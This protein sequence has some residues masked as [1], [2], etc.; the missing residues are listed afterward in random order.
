LLVALGLLL[1]AVSTDFDELDAGYARL[2]P[3]LRHAVR[4]NLTVLSLLE[5]RSG[6]PDPRPMRATVAAV[7]GRLERLDGGEA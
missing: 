1:T 3:E 5:P 4:S 2:R 6:M 7:L